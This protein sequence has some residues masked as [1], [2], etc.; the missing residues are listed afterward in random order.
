MSRVR[1]NIT[2]EVS[3]ETI[4]DMLDAAGYGI[5][6][7]ATKLEKLLDAQQTVEVTE[8]AVASGG[9]E[10]VVHRTNY[11]TLRETFGKLATPGQDLVGEWVYDYFRQAVE[12]RDPETSEIDATFIDSSAAD[13]WVQVAIFGE[14]VFG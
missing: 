9:D 5:G 7:W 3:D 14:V 2:V 13:A 10:D 12:H 1:I 4:G 11:A 8:S 6:Y